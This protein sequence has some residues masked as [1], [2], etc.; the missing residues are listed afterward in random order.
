MFTVYERYQTLKFCAVEADNVL[1]MV[2]GHM[3]RTVMYTDEKI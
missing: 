2:V 3:A 1:H